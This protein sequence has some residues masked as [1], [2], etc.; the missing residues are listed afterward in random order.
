MKPIRD[1]DVIARVAASPCAGCGKTK[2]RVKGKGYE[3]CATCGEVYVTDDLHRRELQG[4]T[5]VRVQ[6]FRRRRLSTGDSEHLLTVNMGPDDQRPDHDPEKGYYRPICVA[7]Y[8]GDSV[9]TYHK[10]CGFCRKRM[11]HCYS[12]MRFCPRCSAAIANYVF[13]DGVERFDHHMWGP[14]QNE[15]PDEWPV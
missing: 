13:A 6:E 2:Y 11:D 8:L 5:F 10:F 4:G 3:E 7:E 14:E 12:E 1:G 9:Y 15:M